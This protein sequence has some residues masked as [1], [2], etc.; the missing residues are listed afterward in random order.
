M[1]RQS[2]DQ[3]T[4]NPNRSGVVVTAK[5]V[6]AAASVVA[7]LIL[8]TALVVG[9]SSQED[10][11]RAGTAGPALE[12][13]RPGSP[14]KGTA[15]P[16]IWDSVVE[17]APLDNPR[18]VVSL[19]F[20]DAFAGQYKAAEILSRYGIEGTF[21]TPSGS[22]GRNGYLSLDQLGAIAANGHEIGG[23]SVDHAD[24]TQVSE[25]EAM[26]QVCL[27]RKNLT[28]WGFTVTSFAYPYAAVS[29][30]ISRVTEECGYNSARGLGDLVTK[31]H[32]I[33]CPG[34]ESIPPLETHT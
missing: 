32:C 30:E 25:E 5:A 21:F 2:K 14:S 11:A 3:Q 29:P 18:T 9:A 12:Q 24:L 19:T 26:R 6:L 33:G 28:E 7:A 15:E 10:K 13:E 22:I 20:D 8:A 1:A 34:A 16:V 4:A 17:P 23:H 31:N 27:D